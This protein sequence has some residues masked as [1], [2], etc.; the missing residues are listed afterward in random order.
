MKVETLGALH[1]KENTKRGYGNGTGLPISDTE[2]TPP[3]FT[4]D[5]VKI[6]QDTVKKEEV[7]IM[8]AVIPV[9]GYNGAPSAYPPFDENIPIYTGAQP[10]AGT[11]PAYQQGVRFL[12]FFK[13]KKP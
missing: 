13:L 4:Q 6:S 8:P 2:K 7:K 11:F 3:P 10:Q 12:V 9:M 5:T 1:V